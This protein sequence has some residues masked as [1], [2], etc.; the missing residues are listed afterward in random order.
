MLPAKTKDEH[1]ERMLRLLP[2]QWLCPCGATTAT[3][4]DKRCP[5]CDNLERCVPWMASSAVESLAKSQGER[6]SISRNKTRKNNAIAVC[7]HCGVTFK[8]KRSDS[9]YHSAACKQAAYRQRSKSPR[10]GGL[11]RSYRTGGGRQVTEAKW[12]L[13]NAQTQEMSQYSALI[14]K[15][16]PQ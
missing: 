1:R 6:A 14:E 7:Q 13:R 8:P 9:K 4:F 3:N 15:K 12:H 10:K 16:K 2:G 5:Y 11:L